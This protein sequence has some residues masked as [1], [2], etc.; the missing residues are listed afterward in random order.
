[1]VA[2]C[3]NVPPLKRTQS[4][5]AVGVVNNGTADKNTYVSNVAVGA[6]AEKI[7]NVR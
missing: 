3:R 5:T 4:D 7:I 1:M 6:A 2:A